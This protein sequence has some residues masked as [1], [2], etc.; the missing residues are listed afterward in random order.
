MDIRIKLNYAFQ[1]Y[2]GNH[3]IVEV[4]GNTVKEC[5]DSLIDLYPIFKE[6]L[7]SNDDT[8]SALVLY[9]GETIVPKDLDRPVTEESELVLLPMIQG[10]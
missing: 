8:L 7:F 4:R 5:L 1:P 6:L 9:D 10:G 3:E 2:A